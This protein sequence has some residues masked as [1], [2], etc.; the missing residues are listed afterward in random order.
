MNIL[1]LQ[2]RFLLVLNLLLRV[3]ITQVILMKLVYILHWLV[4]VNIRSYS[5]IGSLLII[6]TVVFVSLWIIKLFTLIVQC[7]NI[8]VLRW[9]RIS[10]LHIL[11]LTF[12]TA[13]HSV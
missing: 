4:I 8:P 10:M 12:T 1:W 9:N 11:T 2:R 5:N 6:K 13:T 3:S 7:I